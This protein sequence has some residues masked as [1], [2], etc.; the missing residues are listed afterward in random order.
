MFYRDQDQAAAGNVVIGP[1]RKTMQ[2]ERIE[3]VTA[4]LKAVRQVSGC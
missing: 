1:Y 3:E 4:R 2:K